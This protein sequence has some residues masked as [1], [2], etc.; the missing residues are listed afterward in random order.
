MVRFYYDDYDFNPDKKY[1]IF[2][3]GGFTCGATR[4]HFSLVEKYS[5]L[6]NVKY[7]IS[8]IGNE[9][10]HGVPYALNRKIWKIYIRELLPKDRIILKKAYSMDDV[11]DEIDGIDVVIFIR[12]KEEENIKEKEKERRERYRRVFNRLKRRGVQVDFLIIDRPEKNVLSAIKFV[13]ALKR[14]DSYEKL[15]FFLPK[16]LPD[17]E[18]KYIIRNLKKQ[19]LIV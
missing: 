18:C 10:R 5:H 7:Y 4:G 15:K 16:N 3:R 17:S 2:F 6:E 11:L 14:G 19:K 1:L 9:S 12:G 8:Q 13:E